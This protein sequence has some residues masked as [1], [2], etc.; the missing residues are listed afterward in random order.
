M[1]VVRTRSSAPWSGEKLDL[2]EPAPSCA[3]RPNSE[4]LHFALE[5]FNLEALSSHA[6]ALFSVST[7]LHYS[8][9]K[10]M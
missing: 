3:L 5:M 7:S 9:H 6:H 10:A 1:V 4:H 2:K 8:T